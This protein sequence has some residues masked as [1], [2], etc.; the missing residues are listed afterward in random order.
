M[1]AIILL[2]ILIPT[3]YLILLIAI[4]YRTGDNR[5]LLQSLEKEVTKLKTQV[6]TLVQEFKNTNS[7]TVTS[8]IIIAEAT[9][10]IIIPEDPVIKE[11]EPVIETNIASVPTINEQVV[12]SEPTPSFATEAEE[13]DNIFYPIY[14]TK[15]TY[16]KKE[17]DL[18]RFIG[19]NLSNKIG[20]AVLVLGIAFFIRYA[21][22]KN[23]VHESGRVIIGLISGVVLIGLAHYYRNKYRSFSSVLVGGGLTVFYI[24][25]A[26]AFHQYQLIGQLAAFLIMVLITA[27]GVILSLYYNRLELAILATIGGFITPF[28]VSTGQ[29][30]Y[31]ALF[32]YLCILNTGLMVLAW[33]KRWPAINTIALFFTTFIFTGWLINRLAFQNTINFPYKNA[34]LFATLFYALFVA[35]N[36]INTI[37]LKNKFK[38]FDFIVL[39]ST[40]FLYFI[41]A[42]LILKYW[43]HGTYKGLFTGLL[44]TINLI[45][46]ALFYQKKSVDRNFI[47]LLIGLSLLFVSLVAPVEFK[48]NY[49]VLFWAAEAVV[50]FWLYQRSGIA[51]LQK[52]TYIV[53]T[54]MICSLVINWADVYL[55]SSDI[56][57][58]IFNKGFITSFI[59]CI[60]LSSLYLLH[61]KE[62]KKVD[63][64]LFDTTFIS[65]ILL[66]TALGV[67][68]LSGALEIYYQFSTHF[69]ETSISIIYLQLYLFLTCAA[70]LYVF[71]KD[72]QALLIRI[73]LTF[74]CLGIYIFNTAANVYISI[75]LSETKEGWLFAAHWLSAAVLIGMLYY[76]LSFLFS[77]TTDEGKKYPELLSWI[78][79][80]GLVFV[81]SVE[82][83]H[84]ILWTNQLSEANRYWWENLY[85]KAGLS[86]LWGLCSFTFMWL[87]MN[88]DYK[89]LRIIS[90]SLF[91]VTLV[92][93]FFYDIRNIPPGGKIAA[94][95]LL[96]I[97]LLAVS[98]MY[99][100]LKKIIIDNDAK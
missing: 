25:I 59:A 55:Y 29:D 33:F 87:G 12:V 90:L 69:P 96:G 91:T 94:F 46:A 4:F 80:L 1:D 50:L 17:T 77:K 73:S 81:L 34:F 58:V 19:E 9:E 56:I 72:K 93:L 49:I 64:I 89:P 67:I 5:Y 47:Y 74:I 41:S 68:F 48:G 23:W 61:K 85:Y 57:S 65:R 62:N 39:F 54:L 21:I 27:L 7:Q 88:R 97:L 30:N 79:S 40:N 53:T 3:I 11:S 36:I 45:M 66:F 99:Q 26:F 13:S 22:D 84:I 70:L 42:M 15:P 51:L 52:A 31:N 2:L 63:F 24:S 83:Y 76:L 18:E 92:K 38:G 28:L 10:K 14:E 78:T 95:I 16:R 75:T 100:R 86:I 71:K 37:R 60:S 6:T 43:D 82:M 35:M 98:F 8:P 44:G 20:I 32:T